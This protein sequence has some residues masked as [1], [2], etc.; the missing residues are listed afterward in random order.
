MV[1]QQINLACLSG[2]YDFLLAPIKANPFHPHLLYIR[3][4]YCSSH[5]LCPA[6]IDSPKNEGTD[7]PQARIAFPQSQLPKNSLSTVTPKRYSHFHGQKKRHRPLFSERPVPQK[8]LNHGVLRTFS[9]S[10][11]LA[12][13]LS[14]RGL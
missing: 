1:E 13:P 4:I 14:Q 2:N 3:G 10:A 7:L 5:L 9:S 12:E 11:E 6:E 8:W